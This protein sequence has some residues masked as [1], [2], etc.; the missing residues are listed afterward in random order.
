MSLVSCTYF[1]LSTEIWS[2]TFVGVTLYHT[3]GPVAV[4]SFQSCRRGSSIDFNIRNVLNKLVYV[5]LFLSF[6]VHSLLV[7]TRS[8]FVHCR[9]TVFII[10]RL[11]SCGCYNGL[12]VRYVMQRPEIH[13]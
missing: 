11:A 7:I 10:R 1:R 13:K 2:V 12:S 8:P 9:I 4:H 3:I 6:F 5:H